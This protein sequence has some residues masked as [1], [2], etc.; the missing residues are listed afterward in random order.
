[1]K[2]FHFS[3]EIKLSF[4]EL[5]CISLHKIMKSKNNV[6]VTTFPPFVCGIVNYIYAVKASNLSA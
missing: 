5:V 1:M 2:F 3:L 6:A 4:S